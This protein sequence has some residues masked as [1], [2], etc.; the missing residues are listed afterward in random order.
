MG[1][2]VTVTVTVAGPVIVGAAVEDELGEPFEPP[3]PGAVAVGAGG[4]FVPSPRVM[5]SIRVCT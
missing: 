2:A 1:F 4:E 5:A 3:E